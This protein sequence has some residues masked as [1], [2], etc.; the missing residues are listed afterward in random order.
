[1]S[2]RQLKDW[3]AL[4]FKYNLEAGKLIVKSD[5]SSLYNWNLKQLFFY[6]EAEWEHEENGKKL[7]DRM[8]I[9]D[10]ILESPDN[11]EN[12]VPSYTVSVKNRSIEYQI[13]DVY[14]QLAGKKIKVSLN[15]EFMPTIG[16]FFK[17][18]IGIKA[19]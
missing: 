13:R 8:I 14:K 10:W 5:L 1:M 17:V 18:H 2:F 7:S 12:V 15:V 3:D 9:S 16:F 19:G 6:M 4:S 11:R